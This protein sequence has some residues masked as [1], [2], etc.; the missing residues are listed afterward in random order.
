MSTHFR[1]AQLRTAEIAGAANS[2]ARAF[3]DDPAWLWAIPDDRKRAQVLPWFFA[4]AARYGLATGEVHAIG[5]PVEGAV[6]LLPPR[7]PRLNSR[8]LARAGLWQMPVRAG[9]GPFSRFLTMSRVLEERH[10]IDVAPR[11][12][13]VW[14]LGV[15]PPRQR[16]GVGSSLLGP[17]CDRA[18]RESV[19]CYL[20]TTRDRNLAF[21]RQH[22]F[23]VVY[24][25]DFPRGGPHVWTLVRQPRDGSAA[26][27]R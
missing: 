12:W 21:Y 15:D 8:R 5:E 16:Q 26:A 18:D 9:L 11:H 14:L 23:E 24:E 25:G 19:P 2:L 20:D 6:I 7:R 4:A 17:L 3:F 10:T 13:Y 22:G 1:V 27:R